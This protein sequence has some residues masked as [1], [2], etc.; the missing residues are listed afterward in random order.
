MGCEAMARS[1]IR[2]MLAVLECG[3]MPWV[4]TKVIHIQTE[5]RKEVFNIMNDLRFDYRDRQ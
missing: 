3:W 2:G 1:V 4:H 5:W